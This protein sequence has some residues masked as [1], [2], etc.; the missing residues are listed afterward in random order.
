MEDRNTE[1]KIIKKG[2]GY[3]DEQNRKYPNRHKEI[4]KGVCK[5]CPTHLDKLAGRTDPE[6]EEIL[7]LPR[8]VILKEFAFVCAWR[9]NKLCKG[10]CDAAGIDEEFIK[11]QK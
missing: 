1:M 10:L 4:H 8:E 2:M 5:H 7:T 11:N 9:P 3:I 6:S